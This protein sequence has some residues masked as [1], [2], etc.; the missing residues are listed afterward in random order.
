ML[1]EMGFSNE[2]AVNA[3]KSTGNDLTRAIAFLFGEEEIQATETPLP[4]KPEV[5]QKV[6]VSNPQ[7]IPQFLTQ[8]GSGE[9]M[10]MAAMG[11]LY[12]NE[13][14]MNYEEDVGSMD[15]TNRG[16]K[17]NSPA[18]SQGEYGESS[19]SA[20]DF[21]PNIKGEGHLFPVIVAS[22]PDYQIWVS[23]LMILSNY[24]PFADTILSEEDAT[25]ALRELQ[26]IIYF[27][28]NF[29]RSNRWYISADKFFTELAVDSDEF[30]DEDAVLNIYEQLMQLHPGLALVLRS[31]VE[32]T[33]EDIVK[34]LT[35]LE[36]YT[37]TRRPTLYHTLNE[38]FWQKNFSKF[39]VVKYKDVAPVVTFHLVG[40]DHGF[41][42]PF[43][44]QELVYPEIYSDKASDAV[45][46]EVENMQLA[47]GE[48]E[49]SRKLTMDWTIFEGKRIDSL[50]RQSAK[51]IDAIDS[52]SAGDL[53]EL[54]E[55]LEALRLKEREVGRGLQE[56]ASGNELGSYTRVIS[57][58]EDLQ[59]YDLLGVICSDRKYYMRLEEDKWVEM[60]DGVFVDFED[61]QS[62]INNLTRQA[63]NSVTFIY[64]A[65]NLH[66]KSHNLA[67][68]TQP[69]SAFQEPVGSRNEARAPSQDLVSE[70]E[71]VEDA[72]PLD[73]V[74]STSEDDVD[75][76][77]SGEVRSH[78]KC[79]DKAAGRTPL[80]TEFLQGEHEAAQNI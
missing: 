23:L 60:N 47:K 79:Q 70:T 55:E 52:S 30:M 12:Y 40:D 53:V 61:I 20:K 59:R 76:L 8:T 41:T 17:E 69:R 68:A 4:S 36:V 44:I 43:E 50:L 51:S 56:L 14:A 74:K 31:W 66:E 38:L 33:E 27:V 71:V 58:V 46:K 37:D 39:G 2:Q 67:R 75:D 19:I 1:Q 29:E 22:S 73:G 7:E 42:I 78:V 6:Q 57:T 77:K 65:T 18:E 35:V 64:G 24:Q 5:D 72:D 34:D 63:L 10:E 45:R 3:L 49:K 80:E 32:S 25:G 11:D 9:A 28:Q 13:Y 62:D 48:L 21:G 54:A 26:H 15:S 16:D